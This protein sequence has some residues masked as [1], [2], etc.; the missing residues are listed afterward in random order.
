LTWESSN[1]GLEDGGLIGL[2]LE[3]KAVFGHYDYLSNGASP[4]AWIN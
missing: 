4:L 2:N 3:M 1:R